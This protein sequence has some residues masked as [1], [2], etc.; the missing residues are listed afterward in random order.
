[1]TSKVFLE[2][3]ESRQDMI[4][5]GMGIIPT[6]AKT[7]PRL[8]LGCLQAKLAAPAEANGK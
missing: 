7:T 1:M 4:V 6:V 3:G 2:I 5:H 8:T